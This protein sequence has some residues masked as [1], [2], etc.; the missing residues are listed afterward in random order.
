MVFLQLE[1]HPK[2]NIS[3]KYMFSH[4]CDSMNSYT[5]NLS[6]RDA[7]YLFLSTSSIDTLEVYTC[8]SFKAQRFMANYTL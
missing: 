5:H 4:N 7:L 3:F 2:C 6:L 8:M 1:L